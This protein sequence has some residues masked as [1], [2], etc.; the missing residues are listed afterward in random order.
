MNAWLSSLTFVNPWILAGLAALPVLWFLLRVTPPAPKLILLPTARFLDGLV[1]ARKTPS[2][3]PWWILLLRLLIAALVILALAHP[4]LNR[5]QTLQGAGPL[6]IVVDNGWESAQTWAGQTAAAIEMI[7]QASR[8]NREVWITTTAP[9]PANEGKPIN[10]GPLSAGEAGARLKGLSPLPWPADYE[11]AAALVKKRAP[12]IS[13]ETHWLGTGLGGNG[14]RALVTALQ[15]GGQLDYVRPAPEDLPVLLVP[16]APGNGAIGASVHAPAGITPGLP[17]GIQVLSASGQV[18]DS[19]T[20]VL[21]PGK[22]PVKATFDLPPELRRD[23]HRIRISS[24][25]GAG[26]IHHLGV[27]DSY[28]AAGII[29]GGGEDETAPLTESTYYLERGLEPF[30]D[31]RTGNAADLIREKA[32]ILFLPDTGS[33]TA[34]DLNRLEDWIRG[35]GLLVR[36]AGPDMAASD[37]SDILAP[38]QLRLGGRAMEGSLSWDKPASLAPFPETS[39][40]F[41][42]DIPPDVVVRRQVLAEPSPELDEKTWARLEDGTPLITAETRGDGVLVLVHT[43]AGP[44][45]SDLPLSGL[46][47]HLLKRLVDISSNPQAATKVEG[48]LQPLSIMDG[49]GRLVTPPPSTAPI[50][51]GD[52]EGVVPGPR[53]PP[54]IYGRAGYQLALNLGER[55]DMIPPSAQLPTSV[56]ERHYGRDYERDLRPALLLA[57]AGL[58]LFDW[59]LMLLLGVG[60]ANLLRH[61]AASVLVLAAVSCLSPSASAQTDAELAGALYLAYVKTGDPQVDRT[62]ESGLRNL[63]TV[64]AART[65]AEPVGVVAVTPES[66]SLPFFPLV[67]W[68]VTPD[69]SALSEEAQRNVQAYLDRGGTILF[70]TR[71]RHYARG[72]FATTR[73][74]ESLRA[75]TASLDIPALTPMPKEHVLTRS[76]YLLDSMPGRYEGGTIWVEERSTAGRD[77]V[78]SIIIGGHDWAGAWATERSGS[79]FSPHLSGG[80]RQQEMAFRFG[81]NLLMY[82]LTGNYK[83]DQ[84]HVP[85][86]LRRLGQ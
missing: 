43:T 38:V 7:A 50:P 81:V 11:T 16:Y 45:W 67:Y 49:F 85:H 82:A 1:P 3:T 59:L 86:I 55:L 8:E 36:F 58:F 41:G 19:T 78:S 12:T 75:L 30:A 28:A 5:A 40:F 29:T 84:V 54:G 35:G 17:L 51:S 24:R 52:F 46:Y 76:F 53:H 61:P 33:I 66:K 32:S 26:A 15:S 57:A 72:D 77:G 37:T 42:I 63:A 64:M 68:P 9:D 69:Q 74:G 22:L 10:L 60:L 25:D 13:T 56:S 31:V 70:D 2:K 18:L 83:A 73:N 23:V 47:V 48:T 21:E 71:D 4:V 39:P 34:S 27:G 6:R 44:D 62:S 79:T 65:S 80:P 14:F 20:V